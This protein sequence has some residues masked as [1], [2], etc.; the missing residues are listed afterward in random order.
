MQQFISLPSTILIEIGLW[1]DSTD[2]FRT[3]RFFYSLWKLNSTR[4]RFLLRRYGPASVLFRPEVTLPTNHQNTQPRRIKRYRGFNVAM[5]MALVQQFG[6]KFKYAPLFPGESERYDRTDVTSSLWKR[7]NHELALSYPSGA[8]SM[9]FAGDAEGPDSLVFQLGDP[10]LWAVGCGSPEPLRF[11]LAE[12]ADPG[13]RRSAR[14]RDLMLLGDL[15]VTKA[16]NQCFRRGS[17]EPMWVLDELAPYPD[18]QHFLDTALEA[19]FVTLRRHIGPSPIHCDSDQQAI[20]MHYRIVFQYLCN[21]G[22]RIGPDTMRVGI[23]FAH[24]LCTDPHE[25]DLI[26]SLF[27]EAAKTAYRELIPP[28]QARN[29]VDAAQKAR[30]EPV[31]AYLKDY[32]A[33]SE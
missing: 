33:V 11:L 16:L 15:A 26:H 12:G 19:T 5:F 18:Y 20:K 9:P 10:W 24:R 4:C 7:L 31:A 6:A 25:L 23:N 17:L 1:T 22:A 2:I 3:N 14:E 27:N 13:A 32:F 21:R 29:F 8:G 30:N 28:N